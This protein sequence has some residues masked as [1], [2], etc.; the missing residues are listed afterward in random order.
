MPYVSDVDKLKPQLPERRYRIELISWYGARA[1]YI[2]CRGWVFAA[3]RNRPPNYDV[4]TPR[5]PPLFGD[6][7][8]YR[9]SF[10]AHFTIFPFV[11][12]PTVVFRISALRRIPDLPPCHFAPRNPAVVILPRPLRGC[13]L[14]RSIPIASG[15][16]FIV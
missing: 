9:L 12:V 2:F 8:R 4:P 1:R 3:R 14:F 10:L 11:Y 6:V 5:M 15:P 7:A 13:D 16:E